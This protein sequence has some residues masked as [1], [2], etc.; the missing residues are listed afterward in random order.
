MRYERL[1][2]MIVSRQNIARRVGRATVLFLTGA[3]ILLNFAG[4]ANITITGTWS[5]VIGSGDLTGGAGSNLTATYTSATNQITMGLTTSGQQSWRV[6]VLRIDASW[7]ASFQLSIIRTNNGTAGSGGVAGGTTYLVITTTS[8]TF[9]TGY[10]T[11]SG[12][13]LQERLSGVSV[14]IPAATYTTTIQYTA[15]DI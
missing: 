14:S 13:T 4:A 2:D 12:I 7:S 9:V 15:V 10:G 6:D 5:R 3:F 1:K 8:Q 11:R